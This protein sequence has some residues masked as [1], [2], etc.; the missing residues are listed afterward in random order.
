MLNLQMHN[1]LTSENTC[2]SLYSSLNSSN[3]AFSYWNWHL[4]YVVAVL[5]MTCG[6]LIKSLINQFHL[7]VI[8]V[9]RRLVD[10]RGIHDDHLQAVGQETDR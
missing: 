2:C 8:T 7:L 9:V 1:K 3:P 5:L 4:K 10:E 6:F